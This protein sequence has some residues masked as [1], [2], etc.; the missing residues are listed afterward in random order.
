[1]GI[2]SEING[3]SIRCF[4]VG[5]RHREIGGSKIDIIS[6]GYLKVESIDQGFWIGC[7]GMRWMH[8][9]IEYFEARLIDC[10]SCT[11]MFHV[12]TE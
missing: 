6:I 7:L 8:L 3:F 11:K 1:M 10:I 5:L 9:M 4:E 2:E 12:Y